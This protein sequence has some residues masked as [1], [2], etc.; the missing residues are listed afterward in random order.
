MFEQICVYNLFAIYKYFSTRIHSL[1]RLCG[2][3]ELYICSQPDDVCAHKGP[4]PSHYHRCSYRRQALIHRHCLVMSRFPAYSPPDQSNPNLKSSWEWAAATRTTQ[5]D[6]HKLLF[7]RRAPRPVAWMHCSFGSGL[8]PTGG[9][10]RPFA[11]FNLCL[12]Y[13]ER[14]DVE[15]FRI[16]NPICIPSVPG[17]RKDSAQRWLSCLSGLHAAHAQSFLNICA[18]VVN[19]SYRAEVTC[20]LFPKD[21]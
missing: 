5:T 13:D 2:W 8:L 1:P 7:F 14:W 4:S 15:N 6:G 18:W 10:L 16:I 11:S 20:S 21:K 17:K 12:S 9:S 19:T 3:A